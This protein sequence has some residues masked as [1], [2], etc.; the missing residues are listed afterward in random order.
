MMLPFI[1]SSGCENIRITGFNE[2]IDGETYNL[3]NAVLTENLWAPKLWYH[4]DDEC[5]YF[6][7]PGLNSV[8]NECIPVAGKYDPSAGITLTNVGIKAGNIDY[9]NIPACMV[10][11]NGRMYI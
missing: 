7:L 1:L 6:V 8:S 2:V 11:D 5:T 10:D 4:P 3:N 9:H